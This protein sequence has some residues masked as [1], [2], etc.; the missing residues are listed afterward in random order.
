MKD[1]YSI[2]NNVKFVNYFIAMAVILAFAL[3]VIS[4]ESRE[5]SMARAEKV[6]AQRDRDEAQYEARNRN[7]FAEKY[8]K[9]LRAKGHNVFVSVSGL[10]N[11]TYRI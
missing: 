8:Q 6:A 3:S 10:T 5:E 1:N 2:R 7:R 9:D 4:C 11:S